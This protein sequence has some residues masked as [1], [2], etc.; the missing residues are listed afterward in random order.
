MP[1]AF[2]QAAALAATARGRDGTYAILNTRS[3][4]DPFLTFS[5]NRS[6][7]E[8]V[9]RTYYARGDNGD[10]HDNN[11]ILAE[12][13]TLRHERVRLLGY[14]DYAPWRLENRMAKTPS[15]AFDLL[16]AVW[17]AAVARVEAEVADMQAVADTEDAG[18]TIAPWDY[19]YYAEKVR[20]TTYDLDSDAVKQYLQLDN[21]RDGMFFVAGALFDFAFTPITDGSVPVFHDDVSVWD[22]M[23]QADGARNSRGII[24]LLSRNRCGISPNRPDQAARTGSHGTTVRRAHVACSRVNRKTS[25]A[26]PPRSLRRRG[27]LRPLRNQFV[28][29]SQPVLPDLLGK[30]LVQDHRPA[31]AHRLRRGSAP[32][33]HSDWRGHHRTRRE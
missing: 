17:P 22:V 24:P 19:R 3:S 20:K 23:R 33:S 11:A 12:I 21:L 13:V 30:R 8:Q 6:L 4:A 10:T 32:T 26:A 16:D 7:R 29:R 2:V 9:W 27:S 28:G 31:T 25:N 1:D 5:D 18:V 15:Q 14:D